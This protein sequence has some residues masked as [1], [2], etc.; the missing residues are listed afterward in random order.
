[1][2][3]KLLT[4]EEDARKFD[5]LITDSVK[6]LWDQHSEIYE[7][8]YLT[9]EWPDPKM[10]ADRFDM[11]NIPKDAEILDMGCGTGLVAEYLTEMGYSK[12]YG[13]DASPGMM[14]KA[15]Q[16]NLYTD[17]EELYLG[18]PDTFPEKYHNRF[19]AITCSGVIVEGL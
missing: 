18:Q 7:K 12:I 8:V 3:D 16:K 5:N 2:L 13:V 15:K 6:D 17:I 14:E 1:M 19:D 4:M 9:V 10:C 11:F